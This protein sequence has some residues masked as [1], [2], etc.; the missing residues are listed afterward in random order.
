MTNEPLLCNLEG[1]VARLTLNDPARANV[2]SSEMMAALLEAVTTLGADPAV[3]VIVL[4]AAGKVF[5]A[6]H[7]L[8][9][10]RTTNDPAVHEALFA[11]CSELMLAIRACPKPVIG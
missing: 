11:R 10:L 6:G 3:R 9:E 5:C 8:S 4:G 1:P 2:L 7:D